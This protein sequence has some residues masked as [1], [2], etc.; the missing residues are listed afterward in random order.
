MKLTLSRMLR[1]VSALYTSA[2][3]ANPDQYFIEMGNSMTNRR[4][5]L[6]RSAAITLIS[7][8]SF[9][10][11]DAAHLVGSW[12]GAV[13]QPVLRACSLSPV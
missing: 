12:K 1:E 13:T 4:V 7:T 11:S 6:I 3:R 8:A 10:Q 9:S 5:T 2:K